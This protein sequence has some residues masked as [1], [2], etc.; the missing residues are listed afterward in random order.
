MAAKGRLRYEGATREQIEHHILQHGRMAF[1][2]GTADFDMASDGYRP[3]AEE[4]AGT[5]VPMRGPS[6]TAEG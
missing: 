2:G 6:Q 5:S 4:N 1:E 3:L